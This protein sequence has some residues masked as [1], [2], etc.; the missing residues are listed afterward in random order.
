M[1]TW[2]KFFPFVLPWAMGCPEPTAVFHI[3]QAA[4]DFLSTSR[5]WRKTLAGVPTAAGTR[6]YA[7]GQ[8]AGAQ[9]LSI[10]KCSIGT[11]D[12]LEIGFDEEVDGDDSL[13]VPT[14]IWTT[15]LA[16]FNLWRTPAGVFSVV[17]DVVLTPTQ[18][19][20]GIDDGLFEL[21]VKDI[22][23]VA[24]STLLLPG[25]TWS[26][27]QL[28]TFH[29]NKMGV[30]TNAAAVQAQTGGARLRMKRGPL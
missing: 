22:A 17:N 9:V 11:D 13:G 29:G 21:Y 7:F 28:A 6:A 4:I 3:K 5:A 30:A 20:T 8:G 16:N 14:R 12:P 1:K 25:H 15:D 19:A 2:D 27:P 26:N 10:E 24:L 18:A 23:S